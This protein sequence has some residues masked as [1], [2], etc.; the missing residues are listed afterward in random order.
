[1]T[2]ITSPQHFPPFHFYKDPTNNIRSF[3]QC[4]HVSFDC[5][6]L[7]VVVHA[8]N[9]RHRKP[10]RVGAIVVDHMMCLN[11]HELVALVD[12]ELWQCRLVPPIPL[13]HAAATLL[14][15]I[16]SGDRHW[17]LAGVNFKTLVGGDKGCVGPVRLHSPALRGPVVGIPNRAVHA[18]GLV[19]GKWHSLVFQIGVH[20]YRGLIHHKPVKT[21][22]IE[23]D[24]EPWEMKNDWA[25]SHTSTQT[26]CVRHWLHAKA[27]AKAKSRAE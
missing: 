4:S 15:I 26:C 7:V 12:V 20:S 22:P 13:V 21:K 16:G 1:M 14:G 2:S 10:S 27:K 3:L 17:A 23:E 5:R 9:G 11:P 18:H 25:S 6:P 8:F 24:D 19:F